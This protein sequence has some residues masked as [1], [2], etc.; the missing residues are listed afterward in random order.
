MVFFKGVRYPKIFNWARLIR[1]FNNDEREFNFT[2]KICNSSRD[3]WK[4]KEEQL[5][6][7]LQKRALCVK[8]AMT[9]SRHRQWIIL[10]FSSSPFG[11]PFHFWKSFWLYFY[12]IK[13]TFYGIVT[14][15][16]NFSCCPANVWN[17][18]RQAF[19]RRF[20]SFTW[21]IDVFMMCLNLARHSNLRLKSYATWNAPNRISD[22]TPGR[23][24]EFYR[25]RTRVPL[26]F[27][28]VYLNRN[29]SK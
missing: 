3:V 22:Q 14:P 18:Q 20:D 19:S 23:T 25:S 6:R 26:L 7:V 8:V 28:L 17:I 9:L 29:L 4:L 21:C 12:L 16:N 5:D 10:K 27:C 1:N 2:D 11:M 24:F 15:K 13:L